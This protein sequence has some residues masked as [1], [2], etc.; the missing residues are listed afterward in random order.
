MNL[1]GGT[2]LVLTAWQRTQAGSSPPSFHCHGWHQEG[3]WNEGMLHRTGWA[4][5]ETLPVESTELHLLT[6]DGC[7]CS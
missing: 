5:Q 2:P 4:A 3:P 6:R 1:E 7:V